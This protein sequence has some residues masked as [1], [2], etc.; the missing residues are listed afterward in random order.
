MPCNFP[1]HPETGSHTSSL[2]SES[3][4]GFASATTRQN[5]GRLLYNADTSIPL[6]GAGGPANAPAATVC[7]V[8]MVAPEIFGAATFSHES[9][10]NAMRLE[11][12]RE[13]ANNSCALFMMF[14]NGG[15]SLCPPCPLWL[16]IRLPH[17]CSLIRLHLSQPVHWQINH[18]P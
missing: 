5:A 13:D 6:N 1:F 10:P 11:T 12:R 14:L 4:V 2:I 16:R 17:K 8:V 15:T 18:V 9:S 7:A 3:A